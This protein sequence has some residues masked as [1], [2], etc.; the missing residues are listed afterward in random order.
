M[1]LAQEICIARRRDKTSTFQAGVTFEHPETSGIWSPAGYV[2][3][4]IGVSCSL[5]DVIETTHLIL[6]LEH[7]HTSDDHTISQLN[8]HTWSSGL[9]KAQGLCYNTEGIL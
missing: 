7:T 6:G 4:T 9:N 3:I 1:G 2:L 5:G 8:S